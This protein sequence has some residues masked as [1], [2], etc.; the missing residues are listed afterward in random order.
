MVLLGELERIGKEV[1][2]TYFKVFFRPLPG[3]SEEIRKP[4]D[5]Q[6]LVRTGKAQYVYSYVIIV[7]RLR[8]FPALEPVDIQLTSI[9]ARA[10]LIPA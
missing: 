5:N 4:K 7:F 9:A 1:V 3:G 8:S 10:V 2:V 6:C